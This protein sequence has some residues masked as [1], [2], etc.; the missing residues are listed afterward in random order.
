M[1]ELMSQLIKFFMQYREITTIIIVIF[2]V[3]INRWL[4]KF[5][6]YLISKVVNKT[7]NQFF[8]AVLGAYEKPLRAFFIFLPI[9][10]GIKTHDLP[11][12]TELLID[13]IFNTIVILIIGAGLVKLSSKSSSVFEK[14]KEKLDVEFDEIL[15][16]FF[17]RVVQV[18]IIAVILSLVAQAWGHNI[19]NLVAGLGIGG[20][21]VAL[22]AQSTLGNLFGGVV[23]IT[24]KPF[25]LGDWI[26]TPSVEG[27]VEDIGFRST[28]IRTF[29]NSVII[30][31]NSTLANQEIENFS[32]MG[33]RRI[34]FNLGLTYQ[35]TR[36]QMRS[37]VE[38][39]EELIRNHEDVH[40]ETIMVRFD[41]F[42]ESSLDVFI[43]FYTKTTI[44][45]EYLEVKEDIN[46]KIMEILEEEG[47][48]I[49]FPSR[50]LYVETVEKGD[51]FKEIGTDS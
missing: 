24:E 39:I 47:A 7:N 43:Y 5:V 31:P 8:I 26:K 35:T 23:I 32:N 30:I 6:I 27:V 19:N 4:S 36:N 22:A 12:S 50:S 51:N 25:S 9:Y 15:I 10:I 42:N 21:A 38:R 1:P 37:C 3:F 33:K 49:A 2:F 29:A 17:S 28:K 48:S 13:R 46:Y 20:L 44:W 11:I 45:S 14:L 18:I 16:P 34:M 41:K 40:P